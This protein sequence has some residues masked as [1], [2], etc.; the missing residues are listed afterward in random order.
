MSASPCS[1]VCALVERS[2]GRM[3][4]NDAIR[5][6]LRHG[7]HGGGWRED[8][9]RTERRRTQGQKKNQSGSDSSLDVAVVGGSSG[10]GGASEG[11]RRSNGTFTQHRR[12]C[13]H[14]SV[15][16][17]SSLDSQ[18]AERIKYVPL[19]F[20]SLGDS[21]TI[22]CRDLEEVK[23][24]QQVYYAEELR[25]LEAAGTV[26]FCCQCLQSYP[27]PQIR[28]LLGDS[29]SCCCIS[30][31][32]SGRTVA[33]AICCS[34]AQRLLL[35]DSDGGNESSQRRTHAQVRLP[36]LQRQC[37]RSR[38]FAVLLGAD[39]AAAWVALAVLIDALRATQRLTSRR[40]ERWQHRLP[41]W[42]P[43]WVANRPVCSTASLRR[44]ID[45]ARA[46]RM[47]RL[48][49]RH[50]NGQA[51]R[52]E[53]CGA[54]HVETAEHSF[55]RRHRSSSTRR[56][57]AVSFDNRIRWLAHAT[58]G[59]CTLVSSVQNQQIMAL[60]CL[61][62]AYSLVIS[63]IFALCVTLYNLESSSSSVCDGR[64][65]VCLVIIYFAIP[66]LYAW[67]V[68]RRFSSVFDLVKCKYVRHSAR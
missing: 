27:S 59:R 42:R 28:R 30:Q 58:K 35:L 13:L 10:I 24:L 8:G 31:T 48:R 16:S 39:T 49:R 26:S 53:R 43:I 33:F 45:A 37:L 23:A 20:H 22:K 47:C 66:I 51:G 17:L 21:I 19:L 34:R 62:T 50:A 54:V 36:S 64:R 60:N 61:I 5:C 65:W 7:K 41:L 32:R 15:F 63:S 29:E 11:T 40:Q 12:S 56:F 9:P 14:F 6:R 44:L 68:D 46:D 3:M 57:L 67:F 25:A 2:D 4:L 18:A 1:R 52:C 55:V 38:E